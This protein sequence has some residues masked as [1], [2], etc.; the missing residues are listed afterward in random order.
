MLRKELDHSLLR[1]ISGI[2]QK[3]WKEDSHNA[4]N[5]LKDQPKNVGMHELHVHKQHPNSLCQLTSKMSEHC[6]SS[7]LSKLFQIKFLDLVIKL[8]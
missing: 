1:I 6:C 5:Q 2:S 4:I 3:P 8:K 7:S